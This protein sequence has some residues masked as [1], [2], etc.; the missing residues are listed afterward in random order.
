MGMSICILFVYFRPSSSVFT[1]NCIEELSRVQTTVQH[2]I[3]SI[4]PE[5]FT[6]WTAHSRHKMCRKSSAHDLRCLTF[7]H[8]IL[9]GFLL[10]FC[11]KKQKKQP[12][13]IT[14]RGCW[15][16]SKSARDKKKDAWEVSQG[17]G[18][19]VIF[20]MIANMPPCI[21]QYNHGLISNHQS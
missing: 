14:P 20:V 13:S 17:L 2:I 3:Q 15:S 7:L 16:G 1:Q 18:Q 11:V 19:V 4:Y 5:G 21:N 6:P 8:T 10:R 12:T 9:A